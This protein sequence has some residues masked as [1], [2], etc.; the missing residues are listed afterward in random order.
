[1][2]SSVTE[3]T[4]PTIQPAAGQLINRSV[5]IQRWRCLGGYQMRLFSS[6]APDWSNLDD[7]PAATLLKSGARRRVYRVRWEQQDYVA[8][9]FDHRLFMDDI[10]NLLRGGPPQCREFDNLRLA[11]SRDVP[12]PQ[13]I[14]WSHS[15]RGGI[16]LA[17]TIPDAR[18]LEQLLWQEPRLPADQIDL[19]LQAAADAVA[20][21]HRGGLSHH[22][23]HTGNILWQPASDNRSARAVIIDLQAMH[24][25]QRGGHASADPCAPHRQR[26]LVTLLAGMLPRLEEQQLLDFLNTYLLA[27]NRFGPVDDSSRREYR[28]QTLRQALEHRE[29]VARQYDRRVRRNSHYARRLVLPD[30]LRARV[31]LKNKHPHKWSRFSHLEL[32]PDDWRSALPMLEEAIATGTLREKGLN[33][34]THEIELEMGRQTWRL[35]LE[36]S[37]QRPSRLRPLKLSPALQRW[38]STMAAVHRHRPVDW[39][40][41]AVERTRR[42]VRSSW[43]LYDPLMSSENLPEPPESMQL[44]VIRDDPERPFRKILIIKPS[45]LG[46]V[47]RTL[48]L[49]RALYDRY[50]QA[51]ISWLVRPNCAGVLE[52]VACIDR[53]IPFDRKRY[54]RLLTSPSA[55]WVFLKFCRMLRRAQYDLVLDLQGLFRSGFLS[56]LTGAPIRIGFSQAREAAPLFYTHKIV[57]PQPEHICQS[58]WRFADALGLGLQQP[59]YQ[60]GRSSDAEH[61]A[62]ALLQ[63]HQLEPGCYAVL[64][65]GGTHPAKR[66]PPDKF[67]RLADLLLEQHALRSVIMGAGAVENELAQQVSTTAC[68]DPLDLTDS[69]PLPVAIE[70]LRQ[71][72]LT[73]GNDSGLLHIADML[74]NPVIGLYGPTDPRVVGPYRHQTRV[75]EAGETLPR[76]GRYSRN[77]AHAMDRIS[78]DQVAA[79]VQQA[80]ED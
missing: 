70:F 19:I 22:D 73:I 40:L 33:S 50:P 68:S 14:A 23:L 8:K 65:I 29:V 1:M 47:V 80:L 46:D 37:Y 4:T 74:E 42:G 43:F 48:P 57:I 71:A 44:P 69:T 76:K 61:A 25:E 10:K 2:T 9:C 41:A 38:R 67:A 79:A 66:W 77:S 62:A 54:G 36:A 20:R 5:G 45:S 21:L 11:Q 16:L 30:G 3:P 32:T 34:A 58:I 56:G 75:I 49:A 59:N 27:L 63:Q 24:I 6:S 13:A 7:D 39:P 64:L 35:R 18:T 12:V 60:L 55:L 28:D 31:Y 17:A 51:A 72:Q 26:N 78:L 53:I 52:G 15:W